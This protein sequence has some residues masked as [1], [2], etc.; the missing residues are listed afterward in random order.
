M[1]LLVG[2]RSRNPVALYYIVPLIWGIS[3]HL[4][5]YAIDA[6]APHY[7]LL[8]ICGKDIIG[9]LCFERHVCDIANSCI[10]YNILLRGRD[11]VS[12]DSNTFAL[13]IS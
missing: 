2:S 11:L 13:V 9:D 3:V 5:H 10:M 6:I 8:L 1:F 4:M 7:I 12:N